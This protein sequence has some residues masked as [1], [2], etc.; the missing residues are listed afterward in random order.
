MIKK[1]LLSFFFF[2]GFSLYAQTYIMSSTPLT[3]C[4]GTHEDPGGAGN[5]ADNSNFTQT[6]CSASGNCVSLTFTSF[7][8]ES[9]FDFL[10]IHDGPSASSPQV[11]GSPFTGSSSPGT[12]TCTSGCM[13]LVFTSD[14]SVNDIGWTAS[15]SCVTCP[16]P[17]PDL[18]LTWIQRASVPAPARHRSTAITI[19]GRGY[20]GMGHVTTT[21]EIVYDDWWEYDPGTNTW[22]QKANYA[23]GARLHCCGFTIGNYGYVGTGRDVSGVER[24]DFFKY[25]PVSNTW[26]PIAT[27][28]TA[29]LRGSVA[30]TIN[31]KGYVATGSYGNEVWEYNPVTNVWAGK[32]PFPG[33]GRSS[34]VGFSIGTKGYLGTGDIGGSIGDF[35]EYDPV[36]DIWTSKATYGGVPR[37]E[38]GGFAFQGKGYIGTGY[39]YIAGG[40]NYQD[41]WRYD[42]A[43][44]TWQQVAD[45]SGAGRRY[46]SCFVIGLR[47]YGVFGTSG[48]NYNDCWEYGSVS[49]SG[50]E[51]QSLSAG[52]VKT[53]PNP[54]ADN[55][56]FSI[57]N[58]VNFSINASLVIYDCNGKAVKRFDKITDHQLTLERADLASGI[59]FFEFLN[60]NTRTT[61]KFIAQ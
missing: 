36:T 21:P 25:D 52:E 57:S 20:A 27:I 22:T 30:F 61:G 26:T 56:T 40:V 19:G 10:E 32:S 18:T 48:T 41:F 46:L 1:L 23:G 13:T 53:F 35:W 28:P 24:S 50:I 14:F 37:L 33:P 38:A 51:E 15:I 43:T 31:G 58:N 60:N 6:I 45:F 59:Y 17:P 34:A 5:Y 44:N 16:P 49:A 12:V 4:S 54:F 47:A 42:P 29:G 9:G 7:S 39:D 11:T 55:L 3:T 2:S 8:I